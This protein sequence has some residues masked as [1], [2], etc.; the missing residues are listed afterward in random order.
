ASGNGWRDA[1][2]QGSGTG[3]RA[4]SGRETAGEEKR[5]RERRQP[6]RELSCCRIRAAISL[7]PFRSAVISFA[8]MRKAK[9]AA[10]AD[11][12]EVPAKASGESPLSLSRLREAF[13]AMLGS[14]A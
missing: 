10:D 13:A 11:A 8:A 14:S 4:Q 2:R 5:L 9:P 7:D 1:S 12:N 3:R 6:V